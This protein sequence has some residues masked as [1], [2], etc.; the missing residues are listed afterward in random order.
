M[1]VQFLGTGGAFSDFRENYNNNAI[2]ETDKGW[3]L[4]DCGVTAVQS[5]KELGIH[6]S[7]IRG[8]LIT[9]L[10][11]DHASCEQ[12]IWERYYTSP[13]NIPL[14]KPTNIYAPQDILL[15][16][17]ASLSPFIGSFTNRQLQIVDSGTDDLLDLH[18]GMQGQIDDLNFEF[19]A[20]DH[21]SSEHTHKPSYGLKLTRGGK[22][23]LWSG[24]KIFDGDWLDQMANDHHIECIF[25]ECTFA[26]QYPG[27]V[28]THWRQ[29]QTLPTETL[30]KIVIMH[31]NKVPENEDVS[32][33]KG[34]ASR[35]QTF[36]F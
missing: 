27:T 1:K 35:H 24:D 9:H 5:L 31:H 16:L 28:H 14:W 18:V 20:V 34:H 11:G 33:L 4:L 2:I 23:V 29:L 21:V 30:Q 22:T 17:K 6:P 25:H 10:H 3:V 7:E 15:P 13:Q 8:M 32:M 12:F 26:P 36:V 19:F